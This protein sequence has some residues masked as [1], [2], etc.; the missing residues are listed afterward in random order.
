MDPNANLTEQVRLAGEILDCC[1]DVAESEA[2]EGVQRLAELV[3]ALDEWLKGG[4][5]LPSRWARKPEV[6][7]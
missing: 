5:F 3:L 7:G 2:S 4:G 1:D 6:V